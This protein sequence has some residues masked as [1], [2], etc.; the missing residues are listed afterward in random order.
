MENLFHTVKI[1]RNINGIPSLE[2]YTLSFA[3]RI[4]DSG[5]ETRQEYF[6]RFEQ[7]K[8]YV[9]G[10]LTLIS[11]IQEAQKHF[12]YQGYSLSNVLI[13]EIGDLFEADDNKIMEIF[14]ENQAQMSISNK[15]R[16]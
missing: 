5:Y 3:H 9:N 10:K 16:Q 13:L 15:L 11:E 4:L 1:M 6:A 2:Q 8:K 12:L 7:I 14:R